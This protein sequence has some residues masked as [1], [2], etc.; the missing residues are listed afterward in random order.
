MQEACLIQIGAH[1]FVC[2]IFV[3]KR[4]ETAGN[5][6]VC[7]DFIILGGFVA[8]SSVRLDSRSMKQSINAFREK[9]V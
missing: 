2:L 3:K 7:Q 1:V 4:S 9:R 8:K 5:T 6:S